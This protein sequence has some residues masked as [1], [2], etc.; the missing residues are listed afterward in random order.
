MYVVVC[1][2]GRVWGPGVVIPVCVCVC[3][4]WGVCVCPTVHVSLVV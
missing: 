4:V 3:V 1:V 2:W